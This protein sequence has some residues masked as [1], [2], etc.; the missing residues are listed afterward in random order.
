MA[1]LVWKDSKALLDESKKNKSRQLSIDCRTHI[2][3]GFTHDING[4]TYHFSY[5]EEAQ[6]NIQDTLYLFDNNMIQDVHWNGYL[7]GKEGPLVR[8]R[9]SR[10][11][12]RRLYVAS[13]LHKLRT[14]SIYRDDLSPLIN[15]AQS[16]EEVEAVSWESVETP[17][18]DEKVNEGNTL[19]DEL[20]RVKRRLSSAEI[21]NGELNMA[22]FDLVD[23]ILMGGMF[24]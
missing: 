17:S 21:E 10:E 4:I 9:L 18:F 14:I 1:K 6:T 22:M 24:F 2:L 20:E 5:D 16:I 8:L 23:M 11:D 13:T 12:F 7:R 15:Q 3:S 19:P